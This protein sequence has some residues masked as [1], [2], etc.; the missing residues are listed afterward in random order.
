MKPLHTIRVFSDAT[1]SPDACAALEELERRA[2]LEA[3][4]D[5]FLRDTDSFEIRHW[6]DELGWAVLLWHPDRSDGEPPP[7]SFDSFEDRSHDQDYHAALEAELRKV[8]EL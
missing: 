5:Q 1:A 4:R 3:K 8:G 2:E 6:D 7:P